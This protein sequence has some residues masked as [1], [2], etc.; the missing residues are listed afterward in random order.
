MNFNVRNIG[1]EYNEMTVDAIAT[2]TMNAHE[3][4]DL[5]MKM[6]N[7]ASELLYNIN[8]RDASNSCDAAVCLINVVGGVT[9]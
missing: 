2:G 3:C 1:G 5:A 7:A 8:E 6:M 9:E 4:R